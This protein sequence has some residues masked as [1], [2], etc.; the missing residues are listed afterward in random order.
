M[1]K[2]VSTITAAAVLLAFSN[3]FAQDPAPAPAPEA[4]APVQAGPAPSE[5][6]PKAP[7]QNDLK[8]EGKRKAKSKK[9]G[10]GKGH[11]KKRGLDRADEAAGDHGKQGREKARGKHGND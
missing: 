11:N 7:E 1:M 5:E 8:E 4:S 10:R 6:A 9:K 3:L 2:S